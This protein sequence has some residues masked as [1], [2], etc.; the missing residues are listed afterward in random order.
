M[1]LADKY[2]INPGTLLRHYSLTHFRVTTE[3]ATFAAESI[4][5]ESRSTRFSY[6]YRR[7][8]EM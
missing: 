7:L 2:G 6:I 5:R 4:C 8:A 3:S 1:I